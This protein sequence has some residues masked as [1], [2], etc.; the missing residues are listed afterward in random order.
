MGNC[1]TNTDL[2]VVKSS[3]TIKNLDFKISKIA[4]LKYNNNHYPKIDLNDN[5]TVEIIDM[6]RAYYYPEKLD[7]LP[8]NLVELYLPMKYNNDV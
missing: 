2:L 8:M 3:K 1:F 5:S 7:K 6:R 4:F